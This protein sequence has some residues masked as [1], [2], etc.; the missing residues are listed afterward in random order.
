MCG[1]AGIR[2]LG[3]RPISPRE[4]QVLVCALES[5][6]GDATGVALIEGDRFDVL[7]GPVHS[8]ALAGSKQFPAFIEKHLHPSTEMVLLHTRKATKGSPAKNENNHPVHD[9]RVVLVH[10]GMISNDDVVFKRERRVAEVD[11]DA[12]RALLSRFGLA[13]ATKVAEG[14]AG[15]AAI[16][17]FDRRTPG[18]LLLARDSNPLEVATTPDGTLYWAST[19]AALRD[20]LS[21]PESGNTLL[22]SPREASF[23]TLPNFRYWLIGPQGLETEG[24]FLLESYGTYRG[25]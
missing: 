20:V 13:Q 21:V 22:A 8:W 7:K 12:I 2:R 6:G 11:T 10:N 18:K 3:Q 15:V 24:D 9:R 16:A 4:I 19:V 25:Y 17:A 1:I 23:Y 14:L 5:R